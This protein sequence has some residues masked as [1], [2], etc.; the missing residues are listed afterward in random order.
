MRESITIGRERVNKV[1]YN[2]LEKLKDYTYYFDDGETGFV[3][4][5][6][7]RTLLKEAKENNKSLIKY[8]CPIPCKYVLTKGY[9]ILDDHVIVDAEYDYQLGL[10]VPEEY[11]EIDLEEISEY[12]KQ[13]IGMSE[14]II[15]D[16][17]DCTIECDISYLRPN[18]TEIQAVEN[19]NVIK[20]HTAVVDDV[21]FFL[22]KIGNLEWMDS[23]F[24]KLLNP[25][26]IFQWEFGEN[27]ICFLQINLIDSRDGKIVAKNKSKI[28][29]HYARTLKKLIDSNTPP[30]KNYQERI[31]HI[32]TK[33]NTHQLLDNSKVELCFKKIQGHNS[34]N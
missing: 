14:M 23:P 20:V 31:L 17:H 2:G 16:I 32:Y 18:K 22:Y 34:N 12:K 9:E 30:T 13:Y 10:M 27:E 26:K 29:G 21:L 19:S 33:Y 8:E 11:Y 25:N 5:A 15:T 4:M 7:P 3:V 24:N 1:V 28:N 6:I